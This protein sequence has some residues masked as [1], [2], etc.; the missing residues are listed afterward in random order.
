MCGIIGAVLCEGGA[1]ALV[2]TLGEGLRRL[3]YRGYDSAGM[4]LVGGDK[5]IRRARRPGRVRELE[6]DLG[7]LREGDARTGIAHTRWATHG[8]PS[9]A[10]AHP[11]ICNGAVAVVCNGI[12]ENHEELRRAQTEAGFRFTSQTDTEV[13]A[14]EICAQVQDGRDLLGAVQAAA[15]KLKGAY[16]IGAV[17]AGEPG[18]LV[19][20]RRGSPLIVGIADGG[21]L[22][23][24]DVPALL[25]VTRDYLVLEEGD[26][27][28]IVDGAFTVYDAAGSEVQRELKKSGGDSGAVELGNYRHYM[29]KEI[30]EQ[31]RAVAD[32]LEG[33]LSGGHI[34]EEMFGAGSGALF[35][36]VK[37]VKCI[38]CGTSFYAAMVARHWFESCGVPCDVEI[39][40]EFRYRR[41][42]VPDGALVVAVSQSGET[43][44]T[45]EALRHARR[46]GYRDALCICNV[47]ESSLVRE[48]DFVLLTHAGREIGVASTKA[49]TTQL[50][51]LL[52]LV[53]TLGR[54]AAL[55]AA[56]E[57]ELVAELRALPTAVAR[58]L[59]LNAAVAAVARRFADKRHA[60]YL[61]R[62]AHYP[63]A[64][65]GALK[66]KEISY[67]HAEA[68]PA[69]ELKHGPLA[70]VDNDMPVVAVAPN[71]EL[72]VKIKSNIQEVRA[73]GGQL[74]VFTAE[75]AGI[76]GGDGVTVV[77]VPSVGDAVSPIVFTVPLQLLAYHVATIKGTDIDKPRN[78]A[79]A[80]TV[81]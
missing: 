39:A 8:A 47:A 7:A 21:A 2:D 65:E 81:E 45:L 37:F 27:V 77:E 57:S 1:G 3:E 36:R 38:A 19:G 6:Q 60:L 34:L 46:I 72:L 69:G 43:I 32:T 64:L 23:V 28:D 74:L 58:A 75:G 51:A 59:E 44:D 31:G 80:V 53:I 18:R 56:A 13:V 30:F 63:V 26:V 68:Y 16:A 14:H 35:D 15:A 10:N 49:F 11:H 48:S 66:L 41:H 70:L 33:R 25:H 78:L 5:T 79:K 40:S 22:I 61:G 73:R 42:T 50:T 12:V 52:L 71:N 55:A 17:A 20:A 24:S 4:A 54:R 29:E 76:R 62:G 67:I 9:E